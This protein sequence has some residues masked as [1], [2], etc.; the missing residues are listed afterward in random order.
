MNEPDRFGETPLIALARSDSGDAADRLEAFLARPELNLSVIFEGR[1]AEEWAVE[2]GFPEVAAVIAAEVSSLP[3]RAT[4]PRI[5]TDAVSAPRTIAPTALLDVLLMRLLGTVCAAGW[6]GTPSGSLEWGA[7][8]VGGS[9][10]IA[11]V[12]FLSRRTPLQA[13]HTAFA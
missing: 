4:T 12:D 2:E 13:P 3:F 5:D 11:S 7:V 9:D 8:G 1:T 6:A 10:G